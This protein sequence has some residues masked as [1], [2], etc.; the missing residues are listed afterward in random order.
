MSGLK[1]IMLIVGLVCVEP[2]GRV[3]CGVVY[4]LGLCAC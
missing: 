4:G 3:L 2:H 1:S